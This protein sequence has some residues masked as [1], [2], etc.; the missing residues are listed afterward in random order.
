MPPDQIIRYDRQ[1]RRVYVNPAVAKAYG[2]PERELMGKPVGSVLSEAGFAR[3]LR[4]AS[5]REGRRGHSHC[6]RDPRRNGFGAGEL[7]MGIGG[8]GKGYF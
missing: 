1:F 6:S 5:V 7:E 3:F 2:V 4:T 8:T